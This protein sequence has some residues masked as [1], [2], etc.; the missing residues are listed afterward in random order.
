MP[1]LL[2]CVAPA[3]VV[4]SLPPEADARLADTADSDIVELTLNASVGTPALLRTALESAAESMAL[5][6]V[7]AP[8]P[9]LADEA[10]ANAAMWM[11]RLESMLTRGIGRHIVPRPF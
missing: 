10:A 2:R 4:A 8:V 11:S 7:L 5:A 3:A 6:G 9:A 1:W